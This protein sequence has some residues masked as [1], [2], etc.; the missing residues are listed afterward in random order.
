M[1]MISKLF[2]AWSPMRMSMEEV[3]DRLKGLKD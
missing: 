3:D 2:A 1:N